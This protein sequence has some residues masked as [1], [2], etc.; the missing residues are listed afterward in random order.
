MD[1]RL[2]S[3]PMSPLI[4]ELVPHRLR[5][6]HNRIDLV[7][8]EEEETQIV[9]FEETTRPNNSENLCAYM[10]ASRSPSPPAGEWTVENAARI[11][12]AESIRRIFSREVTIRWIEQSA[13]IDQLRKILR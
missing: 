9:H 4:W 10:G 8:H 2:N 12:V 6:Q 11:E 1:L 7:E 5:C 13:N 3:P